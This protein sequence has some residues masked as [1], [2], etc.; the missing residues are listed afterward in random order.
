ML[1]ILE[2]STRSNTWTD[3]EVFNFIAQYLKQKGVKFF[4]SEKH[5]PRYCKVGNFQFTFYLNNEDSGRFLYV[6]IVRIVAEAR[7][8]RDTLVV[9]I[10]YA[11][12]GIADIDQ[13]L[14]CLE[15][16]TEQYL[17]LSS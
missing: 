16:L 9:P 11:R 3:S 6:D 7:S 13:C 4:K 8:S 1:T 12:V 14:S 2:H 15:D 5:E 10:A 17:K